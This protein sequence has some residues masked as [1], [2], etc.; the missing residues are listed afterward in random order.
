[1]SQEEQRVF[2]NAFNSIFFGMGIKDLRYVRE[3]QFL[4]GSAYRGYHLY[5]GKK[6]KEAYIIS[7][8]NTKTEE[9]SIMMSE[10]YVIELGA[11]LLPSIGGQPEGKATPGKRHIS[12]RLPRKKDG[13]LEHSL[14]LLDCVDVSEPYRDDLKEVN[15][16][17]RVNSHLI[18]V[19]FQCPISCLFPFMNLACTEF[20]C[21]AY[22]CFFNQPDVNN[23]TI[24]VTDIFDPIK[25]QTPNRGT[26][27]YWGTIETAWGDSPRSNVASK[28]VVYFHEVRN[29]PLNSMK[30]NDSEYNATMSFYNKTLSLIGRPYAVKLTLEGASSL[31]CALT[32]REASVLFAKEFKEAANTELKVEKLAQRIACSAIQHMQLKFNSLRNRGDWDNL[33]EYLRNFLSVEMTRVGNGNSYTKMHFLELFPE[34]LNNPAETRKCVW[35]FM[36]AISPV[37]IGFLDGQRRACGAVNACL[38]RLPETSIEQLVDSFDPAKEDINL[39]APKNPNLHVLS[40]WM[41]VEAVIPNVAAAAGKGNSQVTSLHLAI[42]RRHSEIIQS[43][44]KA[45]RDRNLKDAITSILSSMTMDEEHQR[46]YLQIGEIMHRRTNKQGGRRESMY[47]GS[48]KDLDINNEVYDENRDFII[49]L[50]FT[51]TAPSV[52]SL[53]SLAKKAI[54]KVQAA[55]TPSEKKLEF[56]KAN[57]G[58]LVANKRTGFFNFFGPPTTR[59]DINMIASTIAN[60]VYDKESFME[61]LEIPSIQYGTESV[62]IGELE[63]DIA[64]MDMS[65]HVIGVPRDGQQMPVSFNCLTC[66]YHDY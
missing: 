54:P 4:L 19:T 66:K 25:S 15:N 55:K 40:E 62:R 42:L 45:A 38:N 44:Q 37:R 53:F 60:F 23:R 1:M 6:R 16:M 13:N 49:G 20:K 29:E 8:K 57:N 2:L 32:G 47:A 63:E 59:A 36:N 35:M 18:S 11:L 27:D 64:E 43:E 10:K 34:K 17:D 39:V 58:T 33:Y 3:V 52:V 12:E 24:N 46:K 14:R 56:I 21:L 30:L 5:N 7:V 51:E 61:F 9:V 65:G 26:D 22:P 41:T 48:T 31:F 50:L 28:A